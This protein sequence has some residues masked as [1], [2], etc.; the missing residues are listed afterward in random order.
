MAA[1]ITYEQAARLAEALEEVEGAEDKIR[2]H[3]QQGG[4]H[5]NN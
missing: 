2:P 1:N 5:E 4:H 3:V